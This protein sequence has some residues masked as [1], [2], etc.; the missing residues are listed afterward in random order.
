MPYKCTG[1]WRIWPDFGGFGQILARFWR[2]WPDFGGASLRLQDLISWCCIGAKKWPDLDR[3]SPYIFLYLCS[4]KQLNLEAVEMHRKAGADDI[5]VLKPPCPSDAQI[6]ICPNSAK[7][8]HLCP[9]KQIKSWCCGDAQ[10]YIKNQKQTTKIYSFAGF[11][12]I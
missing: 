8:D 4:I 3:S 7:S 1:I 12:E 9:I 6:Y 10:N 11:N 2:I 5:C